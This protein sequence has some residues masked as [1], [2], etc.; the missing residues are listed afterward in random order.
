MNPL[1]CDA[2]R[3]LAPE[4]A[5]DVLPG[6]ERALVL[7]H[8][9]HCTTCRSVVDGYADVASALLLALPEADVPAVV[10]ANLRA[11][12]PA[13]AMDPALALSRRHVAR[14][15]LAVAAAVLLVGVLVIAFGRSDTQHIYSA[16]AEQLSLVTSGGTTVGT[17]VIDPGSS[18]WISM[19]V[20]GAL[21]TATYHCEVLLAD[22]STTPVGN[23]AVANG[24]GTWSGPL[25][26]DASHI[27]QVRLISPSGDTV[28]FATYG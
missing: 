14:P 10:E 1:S 21:P 11:T 6:E 25:H 19:S 22:A 27:L 5:L 16:Q 24:T 8:L 20:V 7:E 18:P 17:V 9:H 23:L 2:V 28:A 13:P 3:D 26:V 15:L 4:A 12:S